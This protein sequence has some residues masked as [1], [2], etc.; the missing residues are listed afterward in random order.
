MP[1]P[2]YSNTSDARLTGRAG[3]FAQLAQ[4]QEQDLRQ[5]QV[6]QQSQAQMLAQLQGLYGLGQEAQM[7]PL[8][9][10]ALQAQTEAQNFQNQWA[11]PNAMQAYNTNQAALDQAPERLRGM[12]GQNDAQAFSNAWAQP[13]MQQQY[14]TG[15][16][17]LDSAAIQQDLARQHAAWFDTQQ[18]QDYAKNSGAIQGQGLQNDAQAFQNRWAQAEAQ[19]KHRIGSAQ[20]DVLETKSPTLSPQ[21]GYLPLEAQQAELD[22]VYPELK[23]KHAIEAQKKQAAMDAGIAAD[24]AQQAG[25]G[26]VTH[27]TGQTAADIGANLGSQ[28]ESSIGRQFLNVP[29]GIYNTAGSAADFLANLVGLPLE[30]PRMLG[31]GD[32]YYDYMKQ[33]KTPPESMLVPNKRKTK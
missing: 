26:I 17:N 21:F 20:A 2:R 11:Q 25:Q 18:Q 1:N 14:A 23:A 4:M 15:K 5:Q 6:D 16:S 12:K 33:G 28:L 19:L 31:P 10:Q 27:P 32:I 9:M 29:A 3:K 7:S 8:K 22:R 13:N 24:K 30:T